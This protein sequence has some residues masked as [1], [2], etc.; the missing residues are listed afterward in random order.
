MELSADLVMTPGARLA[1]PLSVAQSCDELPTHADV[2]V[3]GAG[4]IGLSFAWRASQAGLDVA[5][6]DRGEIGAGTTFSATGML[7]A[8]AE[9]EPGGSL[10]LPFALQSQ[11]LWPS[12]RAELEQE[13]G[14]DIDFRP[15]GILLAALSREEVE[16]LRARH[17]FLSASGLD[18]QWVAGRDVRALEPGLRPSACAGIHCPHDHQV[19]PR[20]LVTALRVAL[21]RRKVALVE[22]CGDVRI[23]RVNGSVSGVHASKGYCRAPRVLVA[24]GAWTSES[25]LAPAGLRVPVR[26][27]KGQALALRARDG[28]RDLTRPVLSRQVLSRPVLSRIVWTEQVHLAPKRDGRLIVGATMEEAGFD[29]CVTAGGVYALLEGARRALPCV[30]EM[31]IEAIWTGFR[32]TS[33]DDAP[34]LGELDGA[35]LAIAVGHHRNGILLAPGTAAELVELITRGRMGVHARAL[36]IDRFR[37]ED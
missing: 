6:L 1:P 22:N 2:V 8:A 15:S 11:E 28:G 12:F 17:A 29:G 21:A 32:P 20:A 9:H 25:G 18:C 27:V 34:I 14:V 7:A 24:T 33:D 30:E 37:K 19:D 13:S 31:E 36:T 23:E 26:P 35:G 3:I 10:L 5:V 4:V 16:R